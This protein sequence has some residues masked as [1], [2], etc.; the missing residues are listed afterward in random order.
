MWTAH[1][2][3]DRLEDLKNKF[4]FRLPQMQTLLC[5][6]RFLLRLYHLKEGKNYIWK[7]GSLLVRRYQPANQKPRFTVDIDLEALKISISK[8]ESIFKKAM[9]VDLKDGFRFSNLSR[10]TM[11][12]DTPYGG[13]RFSIEWSLFKKHQSE[14]LK[15][16][17]C[18]GDSIKPESVK[19]SELCIIEDISNI[20]F[21]VYPPEFIF[22]EKLETIV[23]FGTGNTRVK[24]FIDIDI[25]INSGLNTR[26]LKKAV[27]MC[28]ECR[29]RDFQ[30]K[31][32]L[33][34]LNDRDFTNILGEVL[35][36]K[37]EYKKLDLPDMKNLLK[38]I[39][40]QINQI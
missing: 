21:R 16:D 18:S 28:F 32:L 29:G 1:E 36:N 11:K 17:V 30:V 22:A 9:N 19:A 10:D 24:D 26:K 14:S 38:N 7:G 6:E 23:R 35:K 12:R 3:R 40:H 37:R 25:L 4:H 5:Q 15:I 2:I 27:K 8:T 20:S 31:E 39:K 13:E 33:N 34:I